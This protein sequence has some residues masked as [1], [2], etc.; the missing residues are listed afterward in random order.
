M[1]DLKFVWFY[2]KKYLMMV[3][4]YGIICSFFMYPMFLPEDRNFIFSLCFSLITTSILSA[5]L[6][7]VTSLIFPYYDCNKGK[8]WLYL[9]G[10]FGEESLKCKKCN[11]KKAVK[12][13]NKTI[14]VRVFD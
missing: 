6:L 5:I 13:K 12:Y 7:P 8:H 11:Y 9:D 1:I 14:K 3:F 4:G 2:F 10:D